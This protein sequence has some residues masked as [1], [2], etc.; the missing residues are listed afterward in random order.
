MF[1]ISRRRLLGALGIGGAASVAGCTTGLQTEAVGQSSTTLQQAQK[2]A[3]ERVAANPTDIPAPIDRTEPKHH[4]IM[5]E[6]KEVTAEIEDGVTFN[7]MT[8]DGR[9]PGPM[10]RLREGDTVSFTMENLPENKREHNV[11]MHAIYGTGGGSVATTAEPG[12]ANG[13]SFTAMYPGAYIYH[14]AVPNMDQHISTGMFGMVLVEPKAGMP[15]VDREFYLG[16]HE[17]YTNKPV[18][19]QG[20]HSFDVDAMLNET[21]TYVLFNGEKYPYTPD[22]YGTMKAETGETVRVF[23]VT[24]GPNV[25]SNFHPI[26]NV[27]TRAWRDG[28]LASQPEKYVQTMKVPPGSCMVGEMDLPVPSRI[29]LVDH[30][31]TRVTRRGLLAEIDVTGPERLEVFDPVPKKAD[32]TDEEGPQY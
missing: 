14:C 27:W 10:I 20:H 25:S 18:G 12:N 26:G 8:F 16:Q 32:G 17:V 6:A 29:K 11:D 21:P 22:R 23:L 24:G 15:P 28:A 19:E 2:K 1:P 7:F 13:E 3:M 30:A 31:L 5:L 9:V 4:E